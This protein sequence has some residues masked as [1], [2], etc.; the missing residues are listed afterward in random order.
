M[1]RGIDVTSHLIQRIT[2][3]SGSW[4]EDYQRSQKKTPR[5]LT[6]RLTGNAIAGG[7]D[8]MLAQS[9]P[10]VQLHPE[11]AGSSASTHS[12]S[13]GLLALGGGLVVRQVDG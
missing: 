5:R 9:N 1:G 13:A 7:A 6:E 11:F 10:A 2:K 3:A 12:G 4:N 8:G